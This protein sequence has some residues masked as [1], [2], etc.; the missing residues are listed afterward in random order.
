MLVYII[1]LYSEYHIHFF[2]A[3]IRDSYNNYN[4]TGYFDFEFYGLVHLLVELSKI[5]MIPVR[6]PSKV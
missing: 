1:K 6:V 2:Y 3:R 5:R 4:C